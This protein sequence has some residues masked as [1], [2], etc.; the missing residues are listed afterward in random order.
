MVPD[1]SSPT[2]SRLARRLNV[3]DAV[4]I[5]LGS[6]IGAGI[7][8][9]AGPAA[10]VAGSGLLFG[11]I[12]A[13]FLAYLN[14]TTM[15]QLGAVFPESGGAYAYGRHLLG[16]IWGFLAGWGFV[17]GKIASCTAMALTFAA[18]AF[19]QYQKPIA[20]TAVLALTFINYFGV[21]KTASVTKLLVTIVLL[22]LGIVVIGSLFG[23][24]LQTSRLDHWTQQGGIKGIFESAGLMFFAF[25]GYA[26]IATLGEEVIDPQTTIPKAIVRALTITIGL[27]LVT[28][29]TLILTVDINLLKSST[30]PLVLGIESG[31]YAALSPLVRIGACLAALSVLLSL[32]AG[33]GRTLFAMASNG[34]FPRILARVHPIHH[35]PHHA[36]LLVGIIVS[37]IILF[38]DL[39]TSIGL[40]SFAILSYYAIANAACLRLSPSQR[41]WPRYFPLLALIVNMTLAFL[42]P[43]TSVLAG[44]TL[45][46]SGLITY[47][48]IYTLRQKE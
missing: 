9:A 28:M 2:S 39:K 1:K 5:G 34:D 29:T 11:V 47:G 12:I 3:N 38:T 23:G 8:A 43:L 37:S 13:G 4:F 7:F 18:Y 15:A 19:P 31:S 46:L 36:E 21:K 27:Y 20:L 41:L 32:L 44:A 42:L 30:A 40:S 33:V 24:A 16:P 17:I 22:V 45:L 25:A 10:E 35:I 26:R 48:L 6:M 14:A